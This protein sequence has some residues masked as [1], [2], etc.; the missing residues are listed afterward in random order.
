MLLT[1]WRFETEFEAQR[2]QIRIQRYANSEFCEVD[3]KKLVE[4][5]FKVEIGFE[6][7][8][9]NYFCHP[10]FDEIWSKTLQT[11]FWA[12]IAF[13]KKP[14]WSKIWT[15]RGWNWKQIDPWGI[16]S[17]IIDLKKLGQKRF[18]VT[19]E[20]SMLSWKRSLWQRISASRGWNCKTRFKKML[21]TDKSF[22]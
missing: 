1:K 8:V 22:S 14:L 17:D 10:Q 12:V 6:S 19:F 2:L 5:R 11:G 7:M 18:K 4:K 20:C 21:M 16:N 9:M 15:S 13:D 3:L